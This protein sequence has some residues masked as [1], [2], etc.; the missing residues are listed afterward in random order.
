MRGRKRYVAYSVWD[1]RTDDIIIIDG[2]AEESAKAMG[3]TIES[4]YSA[5]TRAKNGSIKR[6]AIETRLF[7]EGE[8]EWLTM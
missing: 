4:F 8:R 3:L 7:E 5:V 6:Y 2:T 1:N